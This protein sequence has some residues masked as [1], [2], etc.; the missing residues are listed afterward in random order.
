MLNDSKPFYKNIDWGFLVFLCCATYVK[1]Y[2]KIA[3]IILYWL[4]LI[5]KR[6]DFKKPASVTWFYFLIAAAG[7]VSSLVQH[8]FKATEYKTGFALGV[9]TWILGGIIS[10]L[11]Y[12]V[13]RN[14]DSKRIADTIKAFF[15]VNILI[16][17]VAL[18][19][20]IIRSK[21][22]VPYWYWE[23]S[24]YFGAST[25]D[26]ITGVFSSNSVTN[27]MVCSL[28]VLY[29]LHNK[30]FRFAF[31]CLFTC[32]L[33]TSNF[34]LLSLVGMLVLLHLLVG[35][36]LIKR[37]IRVSLLIVF[38]MYPVLSPLNVKYINTT[39]SMGSNKS[40]TESLRQLDSNKIKEQIA[41]ST[42][43]PNKMEHSI[44]E[45]VRKRDVNAYYRLPL[46]DTVF[47]DYSDDVK[48]VQ[49]F[50]EAS[51]GAGA[52]VVLKQEFLKELIEKWYGRK[53]E[54]TPLS[55]Y[56]R[57]IKLYSFL[58][59]LTY[60]KSS[61]ANFIFGAGIGNFSSK[62]AIKTTGLNMQGSYPVKDIYISPAFVQYH[63]YTL[64]YVHALPV[65][66]HSTINMPNSVYN[67]IVGEYGLVGIILFAFFYL[68]FFVK[69]W[70]KLSYSR[71]LLLIILAFF[72]FEYWFEMLSLTVVFELLLFKDVYK[73]ELNAG[74]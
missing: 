41:A 11:S 40:L 2:V 28:G 50:G 53:Y 67:Q 19:Q 56:Y 29:F 70:K 48:Y 8:S 21:H 61:V 43:A 62:L 72:G 54:Q 5:Y 25:G 20:L 36:K 10:Y 16:S 13:I 51:A 4:L 71:Y 30:N 44:A 69:K 37:N 49:F 1:L 74:E 57:P 31:A 9:S 3:A 24:E 66:E 45:Y 42:I 63:L 32:L 27:A 17:L 6:Y 59:T 35:D 15:T 38:V 34:T 60:L 7:T 64:L 18:V 12:V 58:Q 65:S 22:L 46:S 33:C 55:T 39:Y 47:V 26:H 14:I 23:A 73:P 68:G 52:N